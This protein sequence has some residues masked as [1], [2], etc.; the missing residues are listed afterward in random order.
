MKRKR[1]IFTALISALIIFVIIGLDNQLV[2][3][4]YTIHSNKIKAPVKIVF[5]ADLHS[6]AYG[7]SQKELIDAINR[8]KPD[9]VLMGGDIADDILPDRKVKELLA[10]IASKY[11]CYY[12]TGNHEYWSGRAYEQ[13]E[14][15]RSYG[16]SVLEGACDAVSLNGQEV[17]VC[18]VDDPAAGF[19]EVRSQSYNISKLVTGAQYTVLLAHRPEL[20][21]HYAQYYFDLILSGHAHGGQWRI[22]FILPNGLFAPNQGLFPQY[23]KGIHED[24]AVKMLISRGLSRESTRVPRFFNPPE[25][26]VIHLEP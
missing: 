7:E 18:G 10:G 24:G 21:H 19:E 20:F 4:D 26:I 25:L 2:I 15:F 5:L 1:I 23:T 12:V 22:P 3:T 17:F 6:C 11:P 8:Q 14:M 16:V 9:V 13:K